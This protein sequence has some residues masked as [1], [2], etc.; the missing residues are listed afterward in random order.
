MI[1]TQ[2]QVQSKPKAQ[3]YYRIT[4][5]LL[6]SWQNIFDSYLYVKESENDEICLEDKVA[7][8]REQATK[9]FV[10]LLNRI[11]VPDNEFMKRGREYEADV[12]ANKDKV[13]SPIVENGAFQVTIKKKIIVADT[14]VMLYGVLDCLKAG[15]IY[16]IKRVSKYAYGKYKR[17]HQH[18]V[19]LYLVPN[20]IDFTY[21]VMDDKEEHHEENYIRE[22]CEDILQT[23]A[24]FISWLKSNDLYE[25]WTQKW[26]MYE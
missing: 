21:L 23:I 11:P 9:E 8:K 5:T 12:Y 7:L 15:K 24:Q 17:S 3:P 20:A 22:N 14:P 19:Y 25:I 6:N 4:P 1:Q 26:A 13:F 2:S 10:D 16:D 18:P